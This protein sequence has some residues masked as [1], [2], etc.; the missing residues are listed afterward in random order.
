M[1]SPALKK[2]RCQANCVLKVSR[3][4]IRRKKSRSLIRPPKTS[5][6]AS[7]AWI[8]RIACYSFPRLEKANASQRPKSNY[9]IQ[10]KQSPRLMALITARSEEH[11]SAPVT[12]A[13]LVCR[14]LLEKKKDKH[15]HTKVL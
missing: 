10:A 7:C 2:A 15:S 12:N 6:W 5:N 13:Q 11:T 8:P 1:F 9:P 3:Q 14:L 4:K